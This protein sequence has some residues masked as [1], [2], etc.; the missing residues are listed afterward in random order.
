MILGSPLPVP[1]QTCA[2]VSD[3]TVGHQCKGRTYHFLKLKIA[4][5]VT[6]KPG[7]LEG[8]RRLRMSACFLLGASNWPYCEHFLQWTAEGTV[9][10]PPPSKASAFT[11]S[12]LSSA[13]KPLVFQVVQSESSFYRTSYLGEVGFGSRPCLCV[14]IPENGEF[15]AFKRFPFFFFLRALLLQPIHFWLHVASSYVSTC[16]RSE[17]PTFSGRGSWGTDMAGTGLSSD[18]TTRARNV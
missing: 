5:V 7:T 18:F 17:Q 14:I 1:H 3:R 8:S 16:P 2:P 15:M 11:S 10:Q 4:L 13:W 12:S 9:T 6:A